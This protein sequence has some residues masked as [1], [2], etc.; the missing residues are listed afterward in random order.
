MEFIS[1]LWCN[2]S[3]TVRL[4]FVE[5]GVWTSSDPL[6]CSTTKRMKKEAYER[7]EAGDCYNKICGK[8]PWNVMVQSAVHRETS[9]TRYKELVRFRWSHWQP[10]ARTQIVKPSPF[11]HTSPFY[12]CFWL[13]WV[14]C[15]QTEGVDNEYMKEPNLTDVRREE[16]TF[17]IQTSCVEVNIRRRLFP[18]NWSPFSE[19]FLEDSE[20]SLPSP[21]W[22]PFGPKEDSFASPFWSPFG[23]KED[24]FASPFWSPFGQTG[25]LFWSPFEKRGGIAQPRL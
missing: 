11:V 25:V 2:W 6:T 7:E 3:T 4:W 18:I 22:S 21:F 14:A 20:D 1:K 13:R 5:C 17:P 24:S 10:N 9:R 8:A 12:L 16:K 19:S 23:P 15:T